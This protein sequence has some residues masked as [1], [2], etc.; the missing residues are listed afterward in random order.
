M[1]RPPCESNIMKSV[2][3]Q[4]DERGE[5]K[6]RRRDDQQAHIIP[7]HGSDASGNRRHGD[8]KPA[9]G[10]GADDAMPSKSKKT[11]RCRSS[12]TDPT[13]EEREAK[14]EQRKRKNLE[15]AKASRNKRRM[16]LKDL[17]VEHEQL[18]KENRALRLENHT[19]R[20]NIAGYTSMIS[21]IMEYEIRKSTMIAPTDIAAAGF[22]T[23]S[24]SFAYDPQSAV[25][26][27]SENDQLQTFHREETHVPSFPV[28]TPQQQQSPLA[29]LEALYQ[30]Q[31]QQQQPQQPQIGFSAAERPMQNGMLVGLPDMAPQL[32]QPTPSMQ[33]PQIYMDMAT[34]LLAQVSQNSNNLLQ[35]NTSNEPAVAQT[36]SPWSQFPSAL[37]PA[38]ATAQMHTC[39]PDQMNAQIAA[40][41]IAQIL[42]N[43]SAQEVANSSGTALG[44]GP[45]PPLSSPLY[46]QLQTNASP[47]LSFAISQDL[48]PTEPM[49]QSMPQPMPAEFQA[50]T[51]HVPGPH[52]PITMPSAHVAADVPVYEQMSSA[53]TG[54]SD[55][56]YHVGDIPSDENMHL[57]TEI[58]LN[59]QD[60]SLDPLNEDQLKNDDSTF[61]S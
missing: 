43:T 37:A 42:A 6:S 12:Q 41:M 39:T 15:S 27:T 33:P 30:Q 21:Q 8:K 5:G 53:L 7:C 18:Q 47:T 13:D 36:P 9:R 2:R 48:P 26:N 57:P 20:R 49:P 16:I 34:A 61:D 59:R 19:L 23:V 38:P 11:R 54:D 55:P 10:K 14:I 58:T 25:L 31:Q 46:A 28:V 44:L 52:F 56:T 45:L 40:L 60:Y 29:G 4:N 51:R 32:I 22:P 50:S 3:Q 1:Y 35:V 17:R 24:T